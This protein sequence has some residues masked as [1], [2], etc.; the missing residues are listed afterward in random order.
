MAEGDRA[1]SLLLGSSSDDRQHVETGHIRTLQDYQ[2]E[3][4]ILQWSRNNDPFDATSE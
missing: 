3:Q 2:D 1:M 4:I